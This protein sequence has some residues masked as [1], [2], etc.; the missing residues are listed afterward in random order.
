MAERSSGHGIQPV[1]MTMKPS[2]AKVHG[3][4]A[5]SAA[6]AQF[7]GGRLPGVDQD[8]ADGDEGKL[9]GERLRHGGE[10]SVASAEY[11]EH[12]GRHDERAGRAGDAAEDFERPEKAYPASA[13]PTVARN[14]TF[15]GIDRI[16]GA[17]QEERILHQVDEEDEPG[18]RPAVEGAGL[19][20]CD[21]VR[22][23]D[24]GGSPE[25]AG[26]EGAPREELPGRAVMM[27]LF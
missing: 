16:G 25:N 23:A 15:A 2:E 14:E 18:E 19:G 24:G 20:R 9:C 5:G 7:S 21:E 26:T 27:R 13:E 11:D 17:G 4:T 6:S 3:E 22:A 1:I 12:G 10:K 8:G